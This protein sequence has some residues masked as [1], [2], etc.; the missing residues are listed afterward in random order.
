MPPV[1]RGQATLAGSVMTDGRADPLYKALDHYEDA[2]NAVGVQTITTQGAFRQLTDAIGGHGDLAEAKARFA[3]EF[4]ILAAMVQEWTE[5]ARG[6]DVAVGEGLDWQQAFVIPRKRCPQCGDAWSP[7][8]PWDHV[9]GCNNCF[10]QANPSG[11]IVPLELVERAMGDVAVDHWKGYPG[12][13]SEHSWS[14]RG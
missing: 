6:V 1:H 8:D 4:P 2:S 5:A 7:S 11:E 14:P 12:T 13:I 3:L 10:A 9:G